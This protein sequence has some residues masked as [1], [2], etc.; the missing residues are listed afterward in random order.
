M[1]LLSSKSSVVVVGNGP[2]VMKHEN[3]KLIDCFTEV[4]R[5]NECRTSGV[6]KFTG[7]KTTIW[8]TFGRGMFPGDDNI[9]PAKVIMVHEKGMPAYQPEHL[10]RIP[11][12]FYKQV[13]D[14]IRSCSKLPKKE[15]LIPSSGYLVLRWLFDVHL[16]NFIHI[17][18]FDHFK[19]DQ[20]KRHHYW[21]PKTFSRP[22]EH[23]GDTEAE[24]LMK[25][26]NTHKLFYLN[27]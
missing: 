12:A 21:N 2:S 22:V 16:V 20:D 26:I 27:S 24:L 10:F 3:G 18:G 5:F 6:E 13:T 23:D 15:K 14:D 1:D 9:R 4:I 19:K 11:H 25:Y 7:T 17:T 8:C